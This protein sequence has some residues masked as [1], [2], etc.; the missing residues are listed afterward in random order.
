[1]V[2]LAAASCA[3]SKVT[4]TPAQN[5]PAPRDSGVDQ[6]GGVDQVSPMPEIFLPD[7]GG[8]ET[9]SSAPV[10]KCKVPV[11]NV[12]GKLKECVKRAPPKAFEPKLKWSWSEPDVPNPPPRTSRSYPLAGSWVI[13]LVANLTDDNGDGAVDLCD[14]PDVVVSVLRDLDEP[15]SVFVLAG[16][17]GKTQFQLEGG[18]ALT[19]TPAIGDLD[20]DGIPEIVTVSKDDRRPVIYDNKGRIKFRGDPA[21][22]AIA[23]EAADSAVSIYDLDA[24]GTPEIVVSAHDVFDNRGRHLF[25]NP[26][27][28]LFE[29]GTD[30][31]ADLDGDGK[32]ELV[33]G[34]AVFY[35]DGRWAFGLPPG[36]AGQPL[37]A[38]F[39]SDPEPEIL[40][41]RPDGVW[42][43]EADGALKFGPVSIHATLGGARGLSDNRSCGPGSVHDFNGDGKADLAVP[44]C[45]EYQVY[46]VSPMGLS[47][48]WAS[49][50]D[51]VSAAAAST[52]FDFLGRGHA[53]A[54]YADEDNLRV[55]DGKSGASNFTLRRTSGTINEYPVVA[56]VDADD[57]AD[58]LLVSNGVDDDGTT[59]RR[60]FPTLQVFEDAQKRWVPSRRIWNQY[61]YFVAN[62]REDGTI[63][64]VMPKHW[65]RHNTFRA[66]AQNEGQSACAPPI[67]D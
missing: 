10:S 15:A 57:S 62:V 37:I 13:P 65:L 60:K 36:P 33:L 39:D 9:A 67:V 3:K 49:P 56:D 66:N 28:S 48:Q 11:D 63:P 8:S 31:A 29:R 14:V 26:W 46:S 18:A 54:I 19:I 44:R 52:G 21:R 23:R 16:D 53:Q 47:L 35:A 17:T 1:M 42:V 5:E 58:V 30:A 38:N 41:V 24:D 32:L 34:T 7:A 43:L 2:G 40:L 6:N 4:M 61:S 45:T 59:A 64:R 25:G 20:G 27:G 22:F 55:F 12:D 51:D 50:I